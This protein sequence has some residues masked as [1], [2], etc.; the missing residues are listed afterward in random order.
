MFDCHGEAGPVDGQEQG[1]KEALSQR[2][3]FLAFGA[4]EQ[5]QK[6]ADL[7]ADSLQLTTMGGGKVLQDF[8]TATGELNK[9]DLT[10]IFRRGSTDD[11]FLQHQ[12]IHQPNRAMVAKLQPFGQFAHRDRVARR[13]AFDGQQRLMLLCCDACGT[14]CCLAEM[15]E[16][17]QRVAKCR[18]H[19]IIRLG[20]LLWSSHV[21]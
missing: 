13:E 6:L 8:F 11:E 16:P 1:I 4:V 3:I 19:F 12:P 5:C 14:C 20:E 9:E 10:T 2:R 21:R 17:P 15:E 7:R 18:Q